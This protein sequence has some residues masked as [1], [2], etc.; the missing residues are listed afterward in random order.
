MTPVINHGYIDFV[1]AECL[2]THMHKI[3]CVFSFRESSWISC[4][5]IVFNLHK[6]YEKLSGVTLLNYDYGRLSFKNVS[7][8][9]SEICE[10]D[11]TAIVFMDH[12]PHPF[13]LLR[14][15]VPKY[16]NRK[17]PKIVFHVFGDFS[18]YYEAWSKL[19]SLLK[20]FPVKFVVAS[21]RQKNFIDNFLLPEH[22]SVVCPFPVDPE[23]FKFSAQDRKSQRENWGVKNDDI[24]FTFTGR[25]SRQKRIHTLIKAF[26]EALEKNPSAS[27]K[28]FIY[29]HADHIGDNFLTIWEAENEYFRKVHRLY[30]KL[31][32]TTR[33][34]I[35]FM[36]NVPNSELSSVY[37]GADYLVNLSV[38]NDEDFGMS[39]AEAQFCGLPAILTDWGGLASFE[40]PA[41]VEAT[42]F[43]KVTLGE[44]SKIVSYKQTVESLGAAMVSPKHVDR[45][46]LSVCAREKFSISASAAKLEK[47]YAESPSVFTEFSNSLRAIAT[48][49]AL[50]QEVYVTRDKK[51]SPI[52]RRLYS[53]YVRHS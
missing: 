13:F 25:I 53:A 26:A 17:K 5:K 20:G 40:H 8:V 19:E 35:H 37:S 43:I 45:Q 2:N 4:Q 3:A 39:V 16:E 18:L 29:G 48:R 10:A 44:K 22:K 28:L 9:A 51:I 30:M 14:A 33:S 41:L 47:I 11:P 6:A 34:R 49:Q 36:G 12:I 42:R 7:S 52:Y 23:E 21:D 27:A 1:T 46:K 15:I 38:H 50:K 24:I 31:P 32:Q